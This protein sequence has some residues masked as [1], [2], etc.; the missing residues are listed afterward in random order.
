M[1]TQALGY[2]CATCRLL[3]YKM[4]VWSLDAC[5]TQVPWPVL[6]F[7][8]QAMGVSTHLLMLNAFRGPGEHAVTSFPMDSKLIGCDIRETNNQIRISIWALLLRREGARLCHVT[9]Y[10]IVELQ[11]KKR[12]SGNV[13]K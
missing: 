1:R 9:L 5:D 12:K 4:T 11:T 10:L 6:V 3:G 13:Q 8:A 7:R 2:Q